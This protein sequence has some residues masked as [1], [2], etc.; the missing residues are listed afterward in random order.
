MCASL[1]AR[2]CAYMSE[3]P[4]YGLREGIL[5]QWETTA[6][7]LSNIA[8]TASPALILPLVIAASGRSAW[9]SV[10][11]ATIGVV[12]I[13]LHVNVFTRDSATPGSLFTFVSGEF[14]PWAGIL[15]G[16]ALL[17]AYV[18][19]AGAVSSGI[20]LYLQGLIGPTLSAPAHASVPLIL[21]MALGGALAYR[22]VELSTQVML[23]LE[24]ASVTTILVLFVFPSHAH[25]LGWDPAQF[26]A[27]AFRGGPV[28]AG[29]LIATFGFT[30][31]ESAAA[32]GAEAVAPRRTIPRA[33]LG[34]AIASGVLF[35]FC[36]YAEVAAI[37]PQ[38]GVLGSGNAALQVIAR[39]KGVG[40]VGPIVS[41]GAMVSFF[42]CVMACLTAASRTALMMG[43]RGVLPASVSRVHARHRTPHVAVV[44]AA[45]LGIVPAA[46]LI[47]SHIN[48]S[49]T[50]EW[51]GEIATYGFMTGYALI[52]VAAPV[53]LVRR[54]QLTAGRATLSVLTIGLIAV[55]VAGS[56]PT[57]GTGPEQWL[58]YVYLGVLVTGCL[59]SA[60]LATLPRTHGPPP[61][62]SGQ[63]EV[64][65]IQIHARRD[66]QHAVEPVEGTPVARDER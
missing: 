43:M 26:G 6:Q 21:A 39:L 65:E 1:T 53:R 64:V 28:L 49:D 13:A 7:S 11:I 31:F 2:Y 55:A 17:I 5:S 9:V 15:A 56:V 48:A 52:V 45:I 19:T 12:L 33:V 66:Q 10:M 3:Q 42:A 16:W 27:G 54:G 63:K 36:T 58:P 22:N 24:C 60:A 4:R 37:E 35:T 32:L 8:P 44:I 61:D 25:G 41:V 59:C 30:G 20:L 51:L 29:I 46:V 40:W 57:G 62:G 18:A 38:L 50:T 23:C 47:L 34:T 14:G